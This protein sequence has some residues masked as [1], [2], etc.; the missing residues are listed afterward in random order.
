METI[1]LSKEINDKVIK[2]VL[3]NNKHIV[4]DNGIEVPCINLYSATTL[5]NKLNEGENNNVA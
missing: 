4:N 2:I 5:F 1:I 3:R